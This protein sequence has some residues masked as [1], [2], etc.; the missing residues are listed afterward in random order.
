MWVGMMTLI[1]GVI[2]DGSATTMPIAVRIGNGRRTLTGAS[3]LTAVP[4]RS[5]ISRPMK[6]LHV[7][8]SIAASYGGPTQS[9]LGYLAASRSVGIDASVAAPGAPAEDSAPFASELPPERL[10]LFAS[11]GSGAGIVSPSLWRWLM[12]HCGDYDVVHVH[13]L[14][15]PVSSFSARITIAA[16]R[17]TVIRPFG[18]MSRYTATH[19]RSRIKAIYTAWI[20]R[21]SLERAA[22]LHFT[23]MA[24]GQEADWF[25][26]DM[27]GRAFVVPPPYI[28]SWSAAAQRDSQLVVFLGRIHPV[29]N[30]EILLAAWPE[31]ARRAPGARLLIAGDGDR[32]YVRAIHEQAQRADATAISFA[33]FL[34]GAAKET[35]FARATVMVLPSH[36]ENFGMVALEAVAHGVPVVVSSGVQLQD[37]LSDHGVARCFAP[38]AAGLADAIV[39]TLGDKS[40]QQHTAVHGPELVRSRFS[41]AAIGAELEAMYRTVLA[42]S[43]TKD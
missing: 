38:T 31:V 42:A 2:E 36:H 11:V 16:R 34:S 41:R 30:L 40:L 29:K 37:V 13:G 21:P 19:R 5:H 12:R 43:A 39:S 14:L 7:C 27:K 33:G 23:T 26:V 15:N 28:G 6:V 17:P 10:H 20:D 1:D 22:A 9:L 3:R 35:L 4:E 8:P 24:E 25:G 32:S 18:T